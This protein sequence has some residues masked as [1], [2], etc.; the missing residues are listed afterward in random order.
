MVATH[1]TSSIRSS[2]RDPCPICGRSK[3]SDCELLRDGR[4]FCHRGSTHHPP[5]W[6]QKPGDHG[7]GADGQE[8]AYLGD[9]DLGHGTFRLHA[10]LNGNGNG[11][12]KVIPLQPRKPEPAPQPAPILGPIRLAR[13]PAD[14]T[15]PDLNRDR[16][17]YHYSDTQQTRRNTSRKAGKVLPYHRD[18][19][20]AKPGAGPDPWPVYGQDQAIAADGWILELEGERC[21]GI[22]MAGGAVAISQPGH[23]HKPE[24]IARRY[25]VLQ[26]A[27]CS[28]VVY[29]SDND[30]EGQQKAKKCATAAAAASLPFL[31]LPATAI[32]PGIPEKGSIDDAPGTPAERVAAIEATI[33]KALRQAEEPLRQQAEEPDDDR[34]RAQAEARNHLANIS[35]KVEL[36]AVLPPRLAD[37]LNRRAAA[38]P[39]DPTTLL[40]PLLTTA[41][42]VVGHRT[43]VEVKADWR[44][45]LVIW[46]GNVNPPGSLKTPAAEVYSVP[47]Q[48]L[49]GE[50]FE[51]HRAAVKGKG[52][53]EEDPPPPRRWLVSDVTYERLAEI[54]AQPNTYGLLCF[55]DELAQ[56]FANLER[57]NGG[58]ARAGWLSLWSGSPCFVD[59][60]V[61]SSSY[62]PKTAVSL[63]GNVQPEKLQ[64]MIQAS[65]N[66]PTS[67]GDG[68]WS[69]FLWCRPP[70]SPWKFT[71]TACCS[72]EEITAM[73]RDLDR[74]P[75]GLALHLSAEATAN[76]EPF[77]NT[78]AEE[79]METSP[80]RAA[81]LSKLRGYSV[82]IAGIL[83][84]LGCVE[85]GSSWPPEVP[86]AVM[87]QALVLSLF[88]LGH[89]D[90]L[91]TEMGAGEIPPDVAAFLRKVKEAGLTEVKPRDLQAWRFWG[92]EKRSSAE[93]LQ[94]LRQVAETYGHGEV[95]Q[96]SRRDSWIWRNC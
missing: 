50:A 36:E 64:A 24:S 28:G 42:S 17:T 93:A 26:A 76:A 77:W 6:A 11:H 82:R 60:K 55:Q 19:N 61:A 62:A 95:V 83:H 18:G 33:P 56:W 20:D 86:A 52:E 70:A 84:L 5:E 27:G 41:A 23:D 14:V 34:E 69:R 39:I 66:D 80:A 94:F 4:V 9:S 54:V 30:K 58:A 22:A 48:T 31:H 25:S 63:F 73:L 15:L 45:P 12:R 75:T 71:R 89:F 67:A 10:P 91:Q 78:W 32:W 87:D 21:A 85:A 43:T 53:G 57:T 92:R 88:F 72:R 46:A 13:L 51:A 79:A 90:A 2:R 49:Q 38:F 3:D 37:L 40:G 16:A 47:L 59:R 96:G 81:F 8:W 35:T 7:Q 65:S 29:V 68:L 74:V 1:A 44:E